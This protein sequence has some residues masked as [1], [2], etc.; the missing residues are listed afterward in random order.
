MQREALFKRF[1]KGPA[2]AAVQE[3][4]R[5]ASRAILKKIEGMWEALPKREKDSSRLMEAQHSHLKALLRDAEA[6][7]SAANDQVDALMEVTTHGSTSS[8]A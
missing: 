8:C 3:V 2:A 5:P 6:R 7:M 1:V 4:S